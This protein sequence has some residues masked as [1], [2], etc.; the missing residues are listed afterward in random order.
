MRKV[1]GIMLLDLKRNSFAS[2]PENFPNLR[3]HLNANFLSCMLCSNTSSSRTLYMVRDVKVAL[4]IV[5]DSCTVPIVDRG[6]L[7]A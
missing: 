1:L 3:A 6:R 7:C 4:G 5:F 2:D